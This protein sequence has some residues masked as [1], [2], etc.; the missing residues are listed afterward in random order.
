MTAAPTTDP[1]TAPEAPPTRAV[2][3]R[4]LPS[5]VTGQEG[6][7]VAIILVLW[8]VLSFTTPAFGSA[9]SWQPLLS[10]V[11]PIALMGV[12]MTMIIITAG[13]D[14]SVG[15]AL[16]VTAV[17]TAKLLVD[18]GVSLVVA[19]LVAAA[20]GLVLGLVNGLLIAY[21]RVQAIIITF[22]TAN[23]FQF[24]GRQIFDNQTVNGIPG[25]LEFFGRGETGRTLGVPHSFV[26]T[27]L[28][29]AAAW[30]WLRHSR[31]GR[32]LYAIGGDPVAARLAGIRVQRLVLMTYAVTG[33]LVGVAAVF[34]V[35]SGTSTLDQS[36]GSGRELAVIAAVV[37]GGTSITGGRGSVL[38]TVLGALLVQ[39]VASG[40]TQLG[41]PSQLSDFF[42]GVAIAIAVGSDLI[43]QRARE[44][45]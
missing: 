25:T 44:Q 21:G 19:V 10:S 27:L 9:S 16:M 32:H 40:T 42:V 31:P 7:L 37:I 41:W 39:I 45:R 1:S 8:V 28:V 12:G 18:Q 4:I 3:K 2:T 38:G 22:G 13:I 30:F 15:G 11:A 17:T 6:V 26:L 34:T 43:R 5:P 33:L 36:V 29:A 23:I 35:A 14:V 20:L 24:L